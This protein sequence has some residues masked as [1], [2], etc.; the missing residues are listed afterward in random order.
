MNRVESL[1]GCC[2]GWLELCSESQEEFQRQPMEAAE[3]SKNRSSMM[4]KGADGWWHGATATLTL[5]AVANV[6]K[7]LTARDRHGERWLGAKHVAMI[8]GTMQELC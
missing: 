1:L 5:A 2:L 3:V 4:S 6:T 7:L 8:S